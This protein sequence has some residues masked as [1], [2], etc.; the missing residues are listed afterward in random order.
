MHPCKSPAIQV[1]VKLA[2]LILV[3]LIFMFLELLACTHKMFQTI[4]IFLDSKD[5]A[6]YL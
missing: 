6:L 4:H 3:W 2:S 5:F 1:A